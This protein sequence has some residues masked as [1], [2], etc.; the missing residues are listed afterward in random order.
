MVTIPNIENQI[1]IT[2]IL[3]C[4]ETKLNKEKKLL[5][6]YQ[7]QKNYLLKNMFV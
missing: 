7:S 6:L 1:Q 5:T 3:D 2:N 4:I